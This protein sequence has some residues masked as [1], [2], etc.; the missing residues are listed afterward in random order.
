MIAMPFGAL[1]VPDETDAAIKTLRLAIAALEKRR[2]MSDVNFSFIGSLRSW[3]MDLPENEQIEIVSS[4]EARQISI[5]V[6]A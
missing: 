2:A 5:I 1:P 4:R 3:K 6:R